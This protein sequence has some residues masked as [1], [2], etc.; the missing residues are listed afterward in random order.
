MK[1]KIKSEI[2]RL[3]KAYSPIQSAEGKYK[4]EAYE[5][6]LTFIDTLKEDQVSND[7]EEAA[8]KYARKQLSN[9]DYPTYNDEYEMECAFEAGAQWQKERDQFTIEL[10]ED[11]AYLAGQ[12]QM[13]DKACEFLRSHIDKQLVIYHEFTWRSRDEFIEGFKKAMEE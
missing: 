3:I 10:A 11:H 12:E 7:L 2:Q 6:L 8:T 5:D 9:P 4:V 13:I 1:E